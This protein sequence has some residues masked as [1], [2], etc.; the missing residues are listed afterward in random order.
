MKPANVHDYAHA[1]I[2]HRLP[3]LH[4]RNAQKTRR[5]NHGGIRTSIEQVNHQT[6]LRIENEEDYNYVEVGN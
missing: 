6:A 1:A 3:V 2:G 4:L 5:N